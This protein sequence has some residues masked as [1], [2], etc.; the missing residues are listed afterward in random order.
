MKKHFRL[1]NTVATVLCLGLFVLGILF[2]ATGCSSKTDPDFLE[3]NSSGTTIEKID[4]DVYRFADKYGAVCYV[5]SG[6]KSGGISCNF[7]EKLNRM[8][9]AQFLMLTSDSVRPLPPSNVTVE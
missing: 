2:L 5:F 6:Y 7:P 4:T 8:T 1:P 3:V 9:D